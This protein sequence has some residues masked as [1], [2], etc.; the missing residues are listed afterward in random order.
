MK[1]SV[2]LI[3]AIVGGL[4][5]ISAQD[6]ILRVILSDGS[7]NEYVIAERPQIKFED[8]NVV[9]LY[10]NVST[11]YPKE[12]IVNF[13]FED[14]SAGIKVLKNGDTRFFYYDNNDRII[15]EGIND[16]DQVKVFSINGIQQRASIDK[17]NCGVAISLSGLSKGHYIISIGNKQSVKITRR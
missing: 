6:I 7:Q 15:I 5:H 9:F 1:R 2:L 16:K 4:L 17:T 10:K 3:C 11:S 12:N 14:T 8:N 13:I